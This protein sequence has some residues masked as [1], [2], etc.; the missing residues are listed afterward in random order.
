MKRAKE[1]YS[2]TCYPGVGIDLI[3]KTVDIYEIL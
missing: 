3:K 1:T 2:T